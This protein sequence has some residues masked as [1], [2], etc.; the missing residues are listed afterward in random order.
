MKKIKLNTLPLLLISLLFIA[1]AGCS[2][3]IDTPVSCDDSTIVYPGKKADDITAK[4]TLCRKISKKTG[5]RFG[6]GTTFSVREKAN[7]YAVVDLENHFN[8]TDR[9][10]M[11]HLDW[12]GPK[13]RSIYRKQIDLSPDDSSSTIYSSISISPDRQP[14]EYSLRIY[15]FRELIA[16]KKFELRPEFQLTSTKAKEIKANI[17]LFRKVSKKTGKH[18]GVG[19]VFTIK[20]KRRVRA[21]IDI[22]NRFA[23]GDNELIFHLDWIGPDHKSIYRKQIDLFPGDSSSVIHSSVSISPS[24]ERQTGLYSLK[25]FLFNH[26]IAEKKFELRPES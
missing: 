3:R 18:I 4:I 1:D 12:I 16:E 5:E 25:V 13:D 20:E 26:L 2:S 14:G 11:F 22:E 17:T 8:L 24:R 9:E 23:F 7:I 15:F 19:T 21:S 6:A 10:L